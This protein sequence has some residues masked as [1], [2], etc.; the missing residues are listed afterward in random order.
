LG[1]LYLDIDLETIVDYIIYT[2]SIK[3]LPIHLTHILALKDYLEGLEKSD[4]TMQ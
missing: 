1:K 3:L 4:K 2:G